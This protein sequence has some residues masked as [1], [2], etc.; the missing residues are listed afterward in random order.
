M[1]KKLIIAHRGASKQAHENT[2]AAFG[3]AMRLGADGIELDVR[4]TKDNILVCF[5][6]QTILQRPLSDLNFKELNIIVKSLGFAVPSLEQA[7]K[8]IKGKARVYLEIKARGYEEQIVQTAIGALRPQDF[9]IISFHFDSLK[10][11]KNRYPFV[12]VGLVLGIRYQSLSQL[13]LRK[14]KILGLVDFFVINSRLWKSGLAKIIAKKYPI[15]I[16]T[17]DRPNAM[18]K[19]FLDERI[20]GII[21]NF[22]DVALKLRS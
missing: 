5:H 20:R 14:K 17:V 10:I 3:A 7:L 1:E 11:I 12:Q 9:A 13:L 8:F 22:P 18:K 16:W 15:L 4:K 21:T 19:F 6:N 2:L